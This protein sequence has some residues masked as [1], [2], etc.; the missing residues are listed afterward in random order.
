MPSRDGPP[1]RHNGYVEFLLAAT[2]QELWLPTWADLEGAPIPLFDAQAFFPLRSYR[3][4]YD[5]QAFAVAQDTQMHQTPL[6]SL[7]SPPPPPIMEM[8]FGPTH[9][10]GADRNDRAWNGVFAAPKLP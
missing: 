6:F 7:L 5:G 1:R 4:V 3:I 2:A 9:R 10:R 8:Q